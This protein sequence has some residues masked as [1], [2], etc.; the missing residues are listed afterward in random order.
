MKAIRVIRPCIQAICALFVLANIALASTTVVPK[1]FGMSTYVVMSGS[2][3]PTI[4][5]GSLAVINNSVTGADVKQ[6]DIIAFDIGE[7]DGRMCIH[8]VDSINS[9]GGE[10]TTRGDANDTADL[11]PVTP[12]EVTGTVHTSIPTVGYILVRATENRLLI[13]TAGIAIILATI[14]VSSVSPNSYKQR[15]NQT[16][17]APCQLS[18]NQNA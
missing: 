13:T 18:L 5:Q 2:M 7:R 16:K 9:E 4:P 12:E 8:R 14:A 6:G 3:E 17:G 15:A 10:I 11:R 1:I